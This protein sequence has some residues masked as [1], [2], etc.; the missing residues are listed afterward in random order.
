MGATSIDQP[1]ISST[2]F[3]VP[4]IGEAVDAADTGE[5]EGIDGLD[6]ITDSL[7]MNCGG[8]G[9]TRMLTTKIPFFREIILS[10]FECESCHWT[11]NEVSAS[12]GSECGLFVGLE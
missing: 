12:L 9:T 6:E 5:D 1:V 4:T 8:T 11:N 2:P 10:S 7:C 3:H